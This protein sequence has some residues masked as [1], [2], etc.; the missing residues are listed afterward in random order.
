[1]SLPEES[2]PEHWLRTIRFSGFTVLMLGLLILAVIVLAPNLRI[3]IEQQQTIA[4]L[5]TEVDEAQESVD[6]LN[7]DAARWNDRAYI[8]SQA[9]DRLYYVY[10]G[11]VSYLVT[12][13]AADVTTNDGVPVST[14][15][16]T[17]KIDW[18]QTLVSS[19][20]TAGLTEDAPDKLT[21]PVIEGPTQ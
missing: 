6:G 16:Q 2:A 8:E 4:Q 15:I 12:G 11:E 20:Y 7:E 19:I 9:R 18:V 1:M 10:P 17:T 13:E 14:S 5:Q 3:L 21:A